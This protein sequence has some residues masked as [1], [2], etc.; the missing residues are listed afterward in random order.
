MAE[1]AQC[2]ECGNVR[3]VFHQC[4]HCGSTDFPVLSSDTIEINLKHG[5]PLVEEALENLTEH[6]RRSIELGIKAI[7]LIHGYGSGGE[8]GQIKRA[9]HQALEGNRFSDR[10]DEYFFGEQVSSGS[11]AY[12]SL[13]KRR[14]GLK[15][16]LQQFKIGNPGITILLLGTYSRSA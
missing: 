4:P 1:M 7:V 14:P 16:H 5:Q 12:Q 9:V 11:P 3:P 10:V 6:L 8:G 13:I 2:L 15:A